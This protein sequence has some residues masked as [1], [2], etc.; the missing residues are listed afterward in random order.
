MKLLRYVLVALCASAGL[1]V[2][3]QVPASACSC[4]ATPVSGSVERADVVFSG[5]L[6]DIDQTNPGGDDVVG[7]GDPVFYSFEVERT[8]KGD[9]G[10]A[11]V[12]S[13]RD[14]ATC[15]L[16][17]MRIDQSYVVFA[18]QD[19]AGELAANLCGGTAGADDRLLDR[20]EAALAP[21]DGPRD[22]PT[23]AATQPPVPTDVPSGVAGPA[24]PASGPPGWAWFGAGVLLAAAGG[25]I[26]TVV[27]G[28]RR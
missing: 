15:G 6:V 9:P 14:G 24:D 3:T 13:V 7:S 27:G 16:E 26:L 4:V 28:V 1:V 21:A 19:R 23:P 12:A 2:F 5:V 20:V 22:P 8:F 17:G 11:V 25:A 18:D 10:D